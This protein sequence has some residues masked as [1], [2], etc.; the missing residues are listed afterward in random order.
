M[1]LLILDKDKYIE[2]IQDKDQVLNMRKVLD[3]IEIVLYKHT[4]QITDFLDPYERRIAES[5]LN[6]FMEISYK[7]LGGLKESE[8]KILLIFPH[9]CEYDDMSIPIISL[10]IEGYTE[11]FCHRDFLGSILNLG[12]NREK[13]GDIL[14][15]ENY[16]Q[17]V[18]KQEISQ[19]V[20]IS[21]KRV[22]KEKVKVKEIPLGELS[23]SNIEYRDVLTTIPSLRLDAI[24][25]GG[26]N[27]SRNDS[28]KLIES[29]KLKVNWEPIQ[30]VSK[31]VVEGDVISIRGYGRFILKSVEGI[32]KKGR[33][34]VK[35]R[36]LK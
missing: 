7:E 24:V 31:N 18:V 16:T 28:Q 27:L 19:F 12:I 32:S 9:Y 5:I 26:L 35:I 10:M 23:A 17:L 4:V 8:R 13:I 34:R 2:H 25:S 33:L 20:L 21:L 36:L 14:I 11:S 3:K 22:G 1:I 15:H 29:G 6:Q 30:R